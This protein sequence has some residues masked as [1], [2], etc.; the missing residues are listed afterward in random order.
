MPLNK[1]V[2]KSCLELEG[3]YKKI[4]FDYLDEIQ[5][6]INDFLFFFVLLLFVVTEMNNRD[7][8]KPYIETVSEV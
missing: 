7:E 6:F 3:D 4:D 1:R 2:E 5:S 8:Q